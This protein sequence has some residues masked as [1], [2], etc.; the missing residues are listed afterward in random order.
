MWNLTA[1]MTRDCQCS[2]FIVTATG[3]SVSV[4]EV[5]D[6]LACVQ[7]SR[8]PLWGRLWNLCSLCICV[9]ARRYGEINLRSPREGF[10]NNA[11]V[12]ASPLPPCRWFNTTI[13]EKEG[14]GGFHWTC[15]PDR[16][17]QR[18]PL[19]W[20]DKPVMLKLC[21]HFQCEAWVWWPLQLWLVVCTRERPFSLVSGLSNQWLMTSTVTP[22]GQACHTLYTPGLLGWTNQTLS[23][24]ISIHLFHQTCGI[25]NLTT[26]LCD[27]CIEREF[28]VGCV[29]ATLQ[30][31]S[32]FI[33]HIHVFSRC[34]G[35]EMLVFLALTVQ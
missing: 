16:L 23:A 14:P 2:G 3:L 28:T 9:R 15:P 32:H 25:L 6:L 34:G 29:V 33:G 24:E 5:S 18:G 10:V 17:W 8:A 26:D 35:S 13:G 7:C 4:C 31:K 11:K 22:C 19:P 12:S 27:I 20:M 30:I 1:F 21:A